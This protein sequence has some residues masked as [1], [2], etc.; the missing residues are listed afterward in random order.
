MEAFLN[1]FENVEEIKTGFS[2][3]RIFKCVDEYGD[4]HLCRFF[5]LNKMAQASD[6]Y[7]VLK[8]FKGNKGF[9]QVEY[10]LKCQDGEHGVLLY[11]WVEGENLLEYF[12]DHPEQKYY[13]GQKAGEILRQLHDLK[14]PHQF[15]IG[16]QINRLKKFDQQIKQ[17]IELGGSFEG[18]EDLL[19]SYDQHKS[20]YKVERLVQCH[21]DFHAN[22]IIVNKNHELTLID[23]GSCHIG[24]ASDDLNPLIFFDD[25]DFIRG[26]F[27]TY[28]PTKQELENTKVHLYASPRA[29]L[30]AKDYGIEQVEIMIDL[31]NKVIPKIKELKI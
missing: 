14:I 20:Q 6:Q 25:I 21:G 9:Q 2:N 24:D 8:R 11:D 22:N 26:V 17:Y 18:I 13:L 15:P 30:W 19:T 12:K 23:F 27:D 10:I 4:Y 29:V 31:N 16:Y 7:E 1:L 3:D 5:K 28:Q